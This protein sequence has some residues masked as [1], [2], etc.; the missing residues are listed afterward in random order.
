MKQPLGVRVIIS[1]NINPSQ[2]T[3]TANNFIGWQ[4]A[5]PDLGHQ[6]ATIQECKH[7][8][9]HILVSW[10]VDDPHLGSKLIAI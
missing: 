9:K 8:K 4:L 6:Q 5:D 7:I 2:S 1:V 10:P 3:H